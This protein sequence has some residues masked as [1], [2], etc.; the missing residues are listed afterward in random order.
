MIEGGT[1]RGL[2]D[3]KKILRCCLLA[4][5]LLALTACGE[6]DLP[7][8][9]PPDPGPQAGPAGTDEP[10]KPED[11]V[12]PV[13]P[14]GSQDQSPTEEPKPPE[15]P[16]VPVDPAVP[17]VVY[18]TAS[19]ADLVAIAENGEQRSAYVLTLGNFSWVYQDYKGDMDTR[20]A[21][22]QQLDQMGFVDL[23]SYPVQGTEIRLQ[24]PE[25]VNRV[26]QSIYDAAGTEQLA[27]KYNM[28]KLEPMKPGA[29][30]Y[31]L[32]LSYS[33]GSL[34]QYVGRITYTN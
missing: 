33:S 17:P 3:M 1:E 11:P 34:V 16:E 25:G 32:E 15:D 9:M 26:K 2:P 7:A 21:E 14:G 23:G 8:P 18:T 28:E 5:M 31:R 20:K 29:Y 24:L 22:G 13:N 27:V 19:P 10:G 12:T 6:P 4:A 30:I